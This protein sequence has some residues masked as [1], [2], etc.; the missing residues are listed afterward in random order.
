M[1]PQ[2]FNIGLVQEYRNRVVLMDPAVVMDI[3]MADKTSELIE[4][5]SHLNL[6]LAEL[7]ICPVNNNQDPT[8]SSKY[9]RRLCHD[10][11]S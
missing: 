4:M 3:E 6:D 1:I 8:Q 9:S 10:N 2:I 11:Q 5:Y 7:I